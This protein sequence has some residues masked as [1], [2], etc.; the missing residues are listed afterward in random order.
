MRKEGGNMDRREFLK[1]G[2]AIGLGV[3]AAVNI[4]G[5]ASGQAP[6]RK[7][8]NEMSITREEKA[9]IFSKNARRLLKLA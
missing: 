8:E 2:G 6:Q 5:A 3:A 4:P 1:T 9:A 7:D